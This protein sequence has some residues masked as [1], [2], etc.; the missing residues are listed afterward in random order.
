[1]CL[2]ANAMFL[3][4]NVMFLFAN[5]MFLF[6]NDMVLLPSGRVLCCMTWGWAVGLYG[7]DGLVP[8]MIWCLFG[9]D[10]GPGRCAMFDFFLRVKSGR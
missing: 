9:N 8:E 2:F 7:A 6:G 4:A 5:D 10:I 3:F 1:M